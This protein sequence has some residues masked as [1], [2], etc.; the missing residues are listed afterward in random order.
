MSASLCCVGR[1]MGQRRYVA[2]W[3][4]HTAPGARQR[5]LP[6]LE[7]F[8]RRRDRRVRVRL[9]RR[10]E[11][12]NVAEEGREPIGRR[13]RPRVLWAIAW[14]AILPVHTRAFAL[15]ECAASSIW[16]DSDLRGPH[17]R[18]RPGDCANGWIS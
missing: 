5:L 2:S 3:A 18:K 13:E 15:S 16:K 11:P 4:E 6:Q 17:R 7:L 8:H 10:H 9:V 1:V 14:A 12:R